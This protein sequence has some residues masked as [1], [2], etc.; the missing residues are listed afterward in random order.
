VPF[1]HPVIGPM[2]PHAGLGF[3]PGVAPPVALS[4][5]WMPLLGR[6]DYSVTK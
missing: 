6:Y 5:P 3:A 2:A 4:P 1:T